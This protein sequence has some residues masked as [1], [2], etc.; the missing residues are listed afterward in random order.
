MRRTL[1]VGNWKMHG[2]RD[3]LGE[4]AA[5]EAHPAIGRSVDVRMALPATLIG[6]AAGMSEAI[7]IGAQDVHFAEAGA[8]TGALSA[9]LLREAGA[10]F[11]LVGHSERRSEGDTDAIVRRKLEAAGRQGLEVILCVG[12]SVE[13]RAQGRGEHV[14]AE[15]LRTSLVGTVPDRLAIAYE[16]LWCIGAA[17]P[18][19]PEQI[20]TMHRTIRRELTAMGADASG[21]TLLYGGAV[22]PH[23]ADAILRADDVDGVLAGRAS[24][25]AASFLA[26]VDASPAVAA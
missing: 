26:L 22:D 25:D 20:A 19:S 18:A 9:A 1:I 13:A 5:I 23:N 24:L 15:Q 17:A 4:L 12:E 21:I 6:E 14:V 8:Y 11:T 3:K 16:P 10:R 7:M 2:S